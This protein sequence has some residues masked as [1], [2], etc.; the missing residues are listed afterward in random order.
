MRRIYGSGGGRE[1]GRKRRRMEKWRRVG[2]REGGIRDNVGL[3]VDVLFGILFWLISNTASATLCR[4]ALKSPPEEQ[5]RRS[6]VEE[7]GAAM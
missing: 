2:E 6:N 7:D 4:R 3:H 1:G 5:R